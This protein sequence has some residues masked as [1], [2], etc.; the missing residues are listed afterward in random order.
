MNSRLNE[1]LDDIKDI[2]STLNNIEKELFRQ[3]HDLYGNGRKGA[4][5]RIETLE[6]DNK[7]INKRIAYFSGAIALMGAGINYFI[8][9]FKG[10]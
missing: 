5:E 8:N 6:E 1:A 4:L 7:K 10:N 2:K 9:F 3:H